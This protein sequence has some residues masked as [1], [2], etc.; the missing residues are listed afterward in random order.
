[1]ERRP[2]REAVSGGEVIAGGSFP[3]ADGLTPPKGQTHRGGSSGDTP[4]Q[5]LGGSCGPSNGWTPPAGAPAP[6]GG[7]LGVQ[8]SNERSR[9]LRQCHAGLKAGALLS[10]ASG[11]DVGCPE[12]AWSTWLAAGPPPPS[13]RVWGCHS[14]AVGDHP[15]LAQQPPVTVSGI[16]T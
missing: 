2:E 6:R 4:P 14:V 12:S 5:V 1:V 7:P 8:P 9:M 16:A 15:P 10:R 3:A 13:L 11:A